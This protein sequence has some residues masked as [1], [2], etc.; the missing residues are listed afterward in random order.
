MSNEEFENYVAL[1]G[2]LLQLKPEQRDQIGGELQDHLQMRVADLTDDGLTKKAAIGQALEE[3]GDAAVMARNFQ[4]IISMKRRRWMMRFATLSTAGLFVVATLLMAMWPDNARFGAPEFST[5]QEVTTEAAAEKT[6][7]YQLSDPTMRNK[8]TEEALKKVVNFD[9]DE[10]PWVDIE[11]EL[12]KNLGFNIFLHESAK[13]DGLP[14]DEP[15]TLKLRD[16]TCGKALEILLELKNAAY[17]IDEGIVVVVSGDVVE[18]SKFMRMKM[19]DCRDL[20]ELLP[21]SYP[22]GYS[23]G[24]GGQGGG[25]QGGGG[26]FCVQGLSLAAQPQQGA[27]T[28]PVTAEEDPDEKTESKSEKHTPPLVASRGATLLNILYSTIAPDSWVAGGMGLASANEVNGILIVRQS[29]SE[30]RKIETLLSDLR[31]YTLSSKTGVKISSKA[32]SRKVAEAV[33]PDN[34]KPQTSADGKSN[35]FGGSDAEDDEDPFG[36]R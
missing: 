3:F 11:E 1:I 16:V 35:L 22:M 33:K 31:V 15:I 14:E 19:F 2:K 27:D 32:F 26:M 7:G 18:D 29:E 10:T 5:A 13:D 20:V 12:E 6:T 9:Y 25:G 21:E 4:T 24:G 34:V 23:T 30:F 28:K 8:K 17:T 36:A